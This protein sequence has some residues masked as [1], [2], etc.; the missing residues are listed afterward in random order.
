MLTKDGKFHCDYDFFQKPRRYGGIALYQLG[1]WLCPSGKDIG[2]HQQ[3]CHEISSIVSGTGVFFFNEKTFRVKAGDIVIS[4][5]GS[6]HNIQSSRH[7][8][9]RY[10]YCGFTL[11]PQAGNG[12]YARLAQFFAGVENSLAVDVHSSVRQVFSLLLNEMIIND[13]NTEQLVKNELDQ[14]LLLT[15]RC[16][17]KGPALRREMQQ[18][19]NF[20]QRMV[21]DVINYIDNNIYGIRKLTDISAQLGYS[22]SYVSQT[23][24]AVMG[25]SLGSYYQQRRFEKAVELLGKS[26]TVTQVSEALGFDSVQSFSRFFRKNCGTPP[27]RYIRQAGQK[28]ELEHRGDSA[29]WLE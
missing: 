28:G 13:R 15:H 2:V 14:L 16:Y 5:E 20:R 6:I 17:E 9:L 4:P 22:Y 27:S 18:S 25:S 24:A 10:S 3:I 26:N 29:I 21:Y 12:Q 23:F 19:E 11:D 1:D 8:P 7:A